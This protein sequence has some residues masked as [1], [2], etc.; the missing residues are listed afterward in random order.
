MPGAW[1]AESALIVGAGMTP[2]GEIGLIVAT[3]GLGMGQVT[4]AIYSIVVFMSLATTL[5]A[6]AMLSYAFKARFKKKEKQIER[7]DDDDG[8]LKFR[9]H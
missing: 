8:R 5:A 2:R 4:N 1:A 6:P 7:E 9:D 3:I